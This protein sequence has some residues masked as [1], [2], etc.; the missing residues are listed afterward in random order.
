MMGPML[1]RLVAV[2]LAVAVAVIAVVA[3]NSSTTDTPSGGH[4]P[5]P[6]PASTHVSFTRTDGTVVIP[7]RRAGPTAPVGST[8]V[9]KNL[10]FTPARASLRM[11]Q[12]VRFVNK[13]DVAHTVLQD[14]GPRS[15]EIAQ[16]ESKRILPGQ[17]FTFVAETAGPISYVCTLHPSVMSGHLNV[18]DASA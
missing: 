17:T 12:S 8:V 2:A 16:F 18:T 6:N 14:F 9:M 3:V 1:G 7:G 13:D 11:G 4:R 15:G 10:R 5:A